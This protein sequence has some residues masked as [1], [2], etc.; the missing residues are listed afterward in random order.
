MDGKAWQQVQKRKHCRGVDNAEVG[1]DTSGKVLL[2]ESRGYVEYTESR[3]GV[4][5]KRAINIGWGVV[6]HSNE[7]ERGRRVIG[8]TITAIHR[9]AASLQPLVL[10]W[11]LARPAS[12]SGPSESR[13]LPCSGPAPRL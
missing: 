11:L 10:S 13:V 3:T 12:R 2:V 6:S 5:H 1:G 8:A 7:M 4:N 9:S